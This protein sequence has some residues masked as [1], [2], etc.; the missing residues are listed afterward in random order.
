M[1][2]MEEEDI[3][4]DEAGSVAVSW[5]SVD[6]EESGKEEKLSGEERGE[7]SFFAVAVR[8]AFFSPSFCR[9]LLFLLLT[10]SLASIEKVVVVSVL[11][12]L[13][14]LLRWVIVI[15]GD[16]G[17]G[18]EARLARTTLLAWLPMVFPLLLTF[19]PARIEK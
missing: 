3:D 17:R 1:V 16:V 7:A 6:E 13:L 10:S 9:P 5:L 4:D 15:V 19:P 8:R 18:A 14:P 11:V 12:K 2:A